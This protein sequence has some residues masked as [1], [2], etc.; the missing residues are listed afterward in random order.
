MELTIICLTY[1][2][3]HGKFSTSPPLSQKDLFSSPLSFYS[4]NHIILFYPLLYDL[5]ID[6]LKKESD[7]SNWMT[8]FNSPTIG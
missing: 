5:I 3:P 1:R 7:I 8:R 6:K 2:F 4:P